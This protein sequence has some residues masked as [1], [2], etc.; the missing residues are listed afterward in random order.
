MATQITG[1]TIVYSTVFSDADQRKLQSSASMAFVWEIHQWPV[2]SPHKRASN[3]M[4]V[5]TE[6]ITVL[7]PG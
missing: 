6:E 5:D 7:F 4:S 3:Y 1:A 2:N